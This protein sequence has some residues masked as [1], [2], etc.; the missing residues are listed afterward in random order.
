MTHM[1]S[2]RIVRDLDFIQR[3]GLILASP[4][5]NGTGTVLLPGNRA[6]HLRGDETSA[7]PTGTSTRVGE[8][9]AAVISTVDPNGRRTALPSRPP[10]PVGRDAGSACAVSARPRRCPACVCPQAAQPRNAVL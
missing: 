6:R 2:C 10:A 7:T 5:V 8:A 4:A 3:G 9:R 1:Q